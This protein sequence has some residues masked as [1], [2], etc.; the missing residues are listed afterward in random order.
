MTPALLWMEHVLG[1]ER[2]WTVQFHT[3]D[4]A[5]S[6]QHGSG[7]KSVVMHEP[8]SGIKFANNEPMRPFFKDSQIN[9]FS[10]DHRGDGIQHAALTVTDIITSV[11]AMRTRGI[12]F[13]PTPSMYYDAIQQRLDRTLGVGKIDEDHQVLRDLEI[14]VDGEKKAHYLL[15]IFLK[16]QAGLFK[17]PRSGS[18]LLRDHPAQG[19]R[20]LRR[21]QLPRA[22]REHRAPAED[23]A[24]HSLAAFHDDRPPARAAARDRCGVHVSE[25][26]ASRAD[27]FVDHFS[28]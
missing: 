28:N 27:S 1:M 6:E 25:P 8:Y 14:L 17:D 19:Q 12:E 9:I 10:E 15:Q 5:K 21:R 22:L 11:R 7:L 16:E 18:V 4:V 3:N 23:G 2:F 20:R 13:M 24:P 26:R